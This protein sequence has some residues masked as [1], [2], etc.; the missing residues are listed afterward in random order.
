MTAEEKLADARQQHETVAVDDLERLAREAI[1]HAR[2][3]AKIAWAFHRD[4]THNLLKLDECAVCMEIREAE[5]FL[6]SKPEQQ[7]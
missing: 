7:P 4:S 3:M 6:D 5:E 2:K 1:A